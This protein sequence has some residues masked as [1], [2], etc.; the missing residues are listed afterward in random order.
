MALD[1]TERDVERIAQI[2]GTNARYLQ[3][4]HQFSDADFA[5]DSQH[6]TLGTQPNQA[7]KGNHNHAKL[8]AANGNQVTWDGTTLSV[9]PTAVVGDQAFVLTG[10]RAKFG[11]DGVA[12]C[13]VLSDNGTNHPIKVSTSQALTLSNAATYALQIQNTAGNLV[14]IGS[15]ANGAF[16]QTFGGQPLYLNNAAADNPVNILAGDPTTGGSLN[17][18]NSSVA[19]LSRHTIVAQVVSGQTG[20]IFRAVDATNSTVLA[21]LSAAGGWS[22]TSLSISGGVNTG[23]SIFGIVPTGQAAGVAFLL[24]RGS[25]G[26]PDIFQVLS[27]GTMA[28]QSQTTFAG[29]TNTSY[30]IRTSNIG[31]IEFAI[32]TDANGGYIQTFGSKPLFLNNAG[33][34]V[35]ALT[36]ITLGA[37]TGSSLQSTLWSCTGAPNTALGKV[38]DVAFRIDTP[39]T[40]NQ[41]IYVKTAA[42]V[43]TGV[44]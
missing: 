13:I 2:I 20:Q 34:A 37:G 32:G 41:R 38:G 3:M 33:N 4:L 30:A 1:L 25:G 9:D 26:S 17:V 6:H 5:G 12:N 15:A 24:I 7:A 28:N 43:W 42:A 29:G 16:I 31:G 19:A 11:W 22:A 23:A 27:T 35:N 10:L 40:A 36:G 21:S 39:T 8:I 44:V 14:T 18:R